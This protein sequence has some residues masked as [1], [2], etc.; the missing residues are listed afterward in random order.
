[1]KF[2][3]APGCKGLFCD[4]F[5]LP[6]RALEEIG[7]DNISDIP[8]WPDNYQALYE[9][10]FTSPVICPECGTPG[11]RENLPDTYGFNMGSDRIGQRVAEFFSILNGSADMYLVRTRENDLFHKARSLLYSTDHK[12]DKYQKTLEKARERDC[13][14]YPLKSIIDD[15]VSGSDLAGRFKVLLE[16]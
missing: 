6:E 8:S 7:E 16:A 3:S 1:M 15:T 5:E 12:F 14:F 13:V 10:W 9:N 2:C 4:T 11:I